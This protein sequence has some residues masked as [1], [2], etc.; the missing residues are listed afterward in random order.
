[1]ETIR[2]GSVCRKIGSGATP[3][4]GSEVYLSSGISLIRS[5]NIYNSGFSRGG[6]AHIN[7]YHAH[8]LDNVTLEPEDILLNITGDSVA[9]CC[10]VS[11]E[12]LPARVNQHVSIIRPDKDILDPRFLRYY[13]ISPSMQAYMLSLSAAGA[14]RN[15]LTKGMIE[16]FKVPAPPIPEQRAIADVLG[17]LDNKIEL[18]RCMNA[19]L[20]ELVR[21]IFQSWFVDFEPFRSGGMQSTPLGTIPKGWEC[22]TWGNISTLE[23]GKSLRDY[24]NA[25]GPFK[26]FGTNGQIGRHTQ[27]LWNS[28]GIVIGRKGAYR[29]VHYSSDPFFVIDTAF[30]L[31]P[32]KYFSMKWAYQ[33]LIRFDI[34]SMDSGSAIPSTSR[35]DFYNIPVVFPPEKTMRTYENIVA[36]LYAKVNAN[37]EQ[38]RTLA[39]LRDALLPRLMSGEVRVEVGNVARDVS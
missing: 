17:S 7:E 2:L 37:N 32:L 25:N 18:N 20:E 22:L 14:T 11:D 6:L 15:A 27:A 10:Q 33:E 23:Y 29:G 16:D 12:I 4:G 36:P 24:K 8:E 21:A 9:R 39:A 38:S 3:K 34:N 28:E 5:Q 31:K 19:T 13:L 1:M 30:Y 35:Q 26:V